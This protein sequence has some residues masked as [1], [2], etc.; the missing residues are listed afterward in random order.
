MV[1]QECEG[2]VNKNNA[3]FRGIVAALDKHYTP[4]S[5]SI[6]H[7]IKEGALPSHAILSPRFV[8]PVKTVPC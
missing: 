2:R 8:N 4:D 3:F 7:M 1:M 6:D 5:N